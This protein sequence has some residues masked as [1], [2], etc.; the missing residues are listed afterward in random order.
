MHDKVPT[1][2]GFRLACLQINSGSDYQSNLSTVSA[3]AREAAGAG[4]QFILTPEYTLMMD[5]SG[6]IMRERAFADDGAP[7]L[8]ATPLFQSG[9][10]R[11]GWNA[12]P[13]TPSGTVDTG[14]MPSRVSAAAAAR[15]VG[16]RPA[17]TRELA[18]FTQR[19][20]DVTAVRREAIGA[21]ERVRGRASQDVNFIMPWFV[22]HNLPIGLVGIFIAA[23]LAA[24]MS[25]IA[26]E[27]NS[28]ATVSVIDLYRRWLRPEGSDAH[29]L[30]VSKLATGFWGLFA[31]VVATF[32]ATLGSL[33]EVVN[34]YGSF[35]YGS[36]LGVFLLA[37]IPRARPLG[38]F[39]GLIVG[40]GAVATLAFGAPQ[41]SFLW[42]NV[43][44]A[45]TVVGVGMLLSRGAARHPAPA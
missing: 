36:I 43:V 4:A 22:L 13:S 42:Q 20:A 45:V 19:N 21:A 10:R 7:A 1:N 29:Y 15:E 33:I 30:L 31:C 18:A 27:L 39:V 17:A 41:V 8:P 14:E 32:A 37:M 40:M 26:A 9:S 11:L 16:D 34:R 25:S 12:S 44:G 38:A 24:A 35:F 3:M 2:S 28:L 5:G 23:V 6:K